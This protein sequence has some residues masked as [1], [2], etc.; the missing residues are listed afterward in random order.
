[1]P[2]FFKHF[3]L[4]ICFLASSVL[5]VDARALEPALG[6][7]VGDVIL[8]LQKQYGIPGV[9]VAITVDGRHAVFNYGIASKAGDR[10]VTDATLF[11]IGS[12]SKTFTATL[13][14]LAQVRKRL[15]FSDKV[16][17]H[18][19]ALKGSAFGA[20]PVLALATHTTGGLPLQ[21]PA[22]IV[23]DEQL[24]AYLGAWRPAHPPGTDRSYS[25]LSAGMLG[26]VAAHSLQGEFVPLMQ[27]QLFAALSMNSTYYAV[28]ASRM[29][30]YAQGY[31]VS[32]SPIRV[33]QGVLG[34][35]S[36]GIK[37]TAADLIRFVDANLETGPQDSELGQA[38]L[39]THIGYFKVG[40]M[41][42]GLIW[43]QY[44]DTVDLNTVLEGSS[45]QMVYTAMP[46]TMI[47]P[48]MPP[49]SHA[50]IHKTGAT[51]GFAAYI[52]FVPYK[53]IGIV[54]LANKSYPN[55]ARIRAA[56][57]IMAQLAP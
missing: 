51:N 23:T 49:Q 54:I 40:A 4:T 2:S 16:G 33:A 42:Q 11:E 47:V 15:N 30:D 22:E 8:P 25:N 6:Q 21:V 13:A 57:Q 20:T 17:D 3:L 24:G 27:R 5:G 46:V 12:I 9:A 7:I 32:D 43:E 56:R 37:S 52:A 48:P 36:Y 55:E 44:A 53:K 18:L 26:R 41:T 10:P 39:Q 29:G 1:M 38:I 14:S 50:L 35:E 19:A 34:A 31:T 45:R 28:P